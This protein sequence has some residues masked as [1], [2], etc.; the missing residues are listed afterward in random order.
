M[1]TK[2]LKLALLLGVVFSQSPILQAAEVDLNSYLGL[3]TQEQEDNYTKFTVKFKEGYNVEDL[4]RYM[5]KDI[6]LVKEL[7]SEYYSFVV[8]GKYSKE[9][10]YNSGMLESVDISTKMIMVKKEINYDS[11]ASNIT[12]AST[13]DPFYFDQ[14]YFKE[15]SEYK[16]ASSIERAIEE[17]QQNNNE[18]KNI[19]IGIVDTGALDHEDVLFNSGQNFTDELNR[20]YGFLDISENNGTQCTS[21]HGLQ[22]AGVIAALRD[23]NVGVSGIVNANLVA[24]RVADV[25]CS[26]GLVEIEQADIANAIVWLSGGSITGMDDIKQSVDIINLSIAGKQVCSAV[27]QAAVNYATSNGRIV[28]TSAGNADENVSDYAPSNCNDV[29]IVANNDNEANKSPTSN[30]GEKITLSALGQN[31]KTTAV[32]ST[33]G[34]TYATVSGTSFSAPVI[35][36]VTGLLKEKYPNSINQSTA[37]YLLQEGVTEHG[38]DFTGNSRDCLTD[39]RCGS[40]VMNAYNSMKLADQVFG[41]QT[42]VSHFYSDKDNCKGSVYLKSMEDLGVK[43]CELYNVKVK[44]VDSLKEFKYQVIRRAAEANSWT[45][46]NSELVDEFSLEGDAKEVT[47]KLKER[48]DVYEYGIRICDMENNCFNSQDLDFSKTAA[49]EYCN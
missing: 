33:Y 42:T 14:K 18:N 26:T 13:N 35:S 49:P 29:I 27:L 36:G 3:T 15:T 12:V 16:G 4:S 19:Y 5:S 22:V 8:E 23:N 25:D 2:K 38:D 24:A 43:V 39:S 28:I 6:T 10:I 37:K 44:E 17:K 11:G 46:N 34:S 31:I 40:G 30:Y 41:F 7:F 21:G 47:Y 45:K 48:N 1:K 32:T 20:E 9:Y